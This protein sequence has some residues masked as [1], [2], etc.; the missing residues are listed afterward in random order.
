M[1][2]PLF[3]FT[4]GIS[5]KISETFWLIIS[6]IILTPIIGNAQFNCDPQIDGLE[7]VCVGESSAYSD[8]GSSFPFL[9][10]DKQW[11]LSGGGAL[12]GGVGNS[13]TIQWGFTP[14][15]Y[16]LILMNTV[17]GVCQES[18][19]LYVTVADN[20]APSMSC[21]DTV[22][23]SLNQN[24]EG[25]VNTDML[26][27]GN[28]MPE[29]AFSVTLRDKNGAIIPGNL[30]TSEYVGEYL[31]GTVTHICSGNYCGPTVVYVEDKLPPMLECRGYD[32]DCADETDP[33]IFGP[34]FFPLKPGFSN[35]QEIGNNKYMV[36]GVDACGDI[37]LEYTE[38]I[39][40]NSC[41]PVPDYIRVIYRDW[42][43][44]DEYGT[45][46]SC[47]DT[48]RIRPGMLSGVIPPPNYDDIDLPVLNCSDSIKLDTNGHP[49]PDVTGY[50]G[51][52]ALCPNIDADYFDY[53]LG[54]C[55][56]SYKIVREWLVA[57]WCSGESVIL[58][59]VIK[60]LDEEIEVNCP[61]PITI[62]T[63]PFSCV[64]ETIVGPPTV[65][66]DC[67][68]WDY[69]VFI[70]PVQQGVMPSSQNASDD[71]ITRL[72]N[73]THKVSEIPVG[74]NWL[75]YLAEDDCGN[76]NECFTTITV[77]ED[78]KP[79]AVCDLHT[80]VTLSNNGKAKVFAEVLDDGSFDNCG[81]S[82]FE[83]RRMDEGNCPP[84]VYDST[85]FRDYVE[86][87]CNDI[88]ENPIMVVLR[89]YDESQN[90]NECMVEIEVQDENPPNVICLPNLV[91]ECGIDVSDLSI[92]GKYVFDEADREN[93]F[94]N[95]RPVGKDGLAK[96]EC[97]VEIDTNIIT[98]LSSCGTGSIRRIFTFSDNF[99][100]P[101]TCT[102]RITIRNSVPL[103]DSLLVWP[104]D[105]TV[106]SCL[107]DLDPSI[108]GEPTWN[109]TGYCADLQATYDDQIF[110]IVEKACY[111]VLRRWTIYDHCEINGRIRKYEYTQVIKVGNNSAPVFDP[112]TCVDVTFQGTGSN[113]S[114][115]ADLQALAEDDCTPTDQLVWRYSI[116]ANN[117]GSFDFFGAGNDASGDYPGG[118]HRIL[119]RVEDQCGNEGTCSY[120]FTIA[121]AKKP[122]PYCATGI[123]TVVMPM[124]GEVDVWASDLDAGSFDN[125]TEQED[126]VFSFSS[127]VRDDVRTYRCSDIPDGI[128]EMF[129][130][131]IWVTDEFG[132]QDY[133]TTK[134]IIQDNVGDACPDT[135]TG[136]SAMIAGD[137]FDTSNEAVEKVMVKVQDT[138]NQMQKENMTDNKGHFAF[139]G[140]PM[141]K[142][143]ILRAERNDNP[144]NGVTTRDLIAIQR[145]LLGQEEFNSPYQYIAA[146][147]NN[148]YHVS[149][150]DII[151][152]RRLIL[153]IYDELPAN[154]SWRF[155]KANQ[156]FNNPN[157]PFPFEESIRYNNLVKNEMS[158]NLMGV[159]IGDVTG[160]A[161]TNGLIGT[162]V[163]SNEG[164]YL[165]N[166]EDRSFRAGEYIDVVLK[167]NEIDIEGIQFAVQY[168]TDALD[169]ISIDAVSEKVSENNFGLRDVNDGII[170][171]S[172]NSVDNSFTSGEE[173]VRF[174]FIA[175]RSGRISGVI[176]IDDF[177]MPA[178]AY[179]LNGEIFQVALSTEGRG[180]DNG[181]SFA[182]LQNTPNPFDNTTTIPFILPES[183]NATLRVFDV[184][185][186]EVYRMEGE[187]QKGR[188][189]IV[190]SKDQLNS[191]GILYYQLDSRLHTAAKKMIFIE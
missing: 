154:Q 66:D 56:G 153:G 169:F 127:N 124:T 72:S 151:E 180:T 97:G 157:N 37:T 17:T 53:R 94:I 120:L 155:L 108:T 175:N 134:V 60:V 98:N 178:E 83:V 20:S 136:T 92:F 188:N 71:F 117:D 88:A 89:V 107:D 138:N 152:L 177:T 167:A 22:Q 67:S 105:T 15:T 43:A 40:D 50:P 131:E 184:T 182:L 54:V 172:W 170:K 189:E 33:S 57:D 191:R 114:G 119:W 145:H 85:E 110:N 132:N 35:L 84:A 173:I 121:D 42:V 104:N 115:F 2:K 49:H 142:N 93:I 39:V 102:Q 135:Q 12:N 186:A 122:T 96:D 58:D 11:T 7:Y 111:K 86:F 38:R 47:T 46:G 123:I 25:L 10:T 171:A 63:L 34:V 82:H 3:V 24:C 62:S 112:T 149:A 146:D 44:T 160:D 95:G 109:T 41:P 101:V 165:I 137:V 133:C 144:L 130:V 13:V 30:V 18:D 90:F 187:F 1:R 185:G 159:K 139:N 100:A 168:D 87:C 190:I 162:E 32:L 103:P 76:T 91:V 64:G 183:G 99:H 73:S 148:S 78:S 19:T 6:L 116:D 65:E 141:Y 174:T 81:I 8:V 77:E 161:V 164:Q 176:S 23:L 113:C 79:V 26:L 156:Q 55:E 28:F 126:L 80:V 9:Q 125:C 147:A 69:S 118:T 163:R 5:P 61:D 21:N 143:Y 45:T 68:S 29:D 179:T 150:K 140:L 16:T 36:T 27:E 31:Y 59:Q 181:L 158:S 14:G 70:M 51:G 106:L 52:D 129:E 166:M 75:I 48:I 4:S 74:K 128:E